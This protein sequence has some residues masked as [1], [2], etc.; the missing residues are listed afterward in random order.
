MG[1][2]T[3]TIQNLGMNGRSRIS[4]IEGGEF[5]WKGDLSACVIGDAARAGEGRRDFCSEGI[6][7]FVRM[8]GRGTIELGV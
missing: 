5:R 7:E 6:Y 8:L 2:T 1:F 4:F 3:V